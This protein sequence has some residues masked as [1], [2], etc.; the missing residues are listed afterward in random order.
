[1]AVEEEQAEAPHAAKGE[2][3]T[4]Q[5]AAVST[6]HDGEATPLQLV[7]NCIGEPARVFLEP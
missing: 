2:R 5:V 3:A 6:Q 1:M 4:D 7:E